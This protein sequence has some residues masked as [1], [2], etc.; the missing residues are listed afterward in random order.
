MTNMMQPS[1]SEYMI[2]VSRLLSRCALRFFRMRSFIDWVSRNKKT[3]TKVSST[4]LCKLNEISVRPKIIPI[5]IKKKISSS[6]PIL[7]SRTASG[8][9]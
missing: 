6:S 1:V 7:K 2:D 5:R 9:T 3:L 8:R 4:D